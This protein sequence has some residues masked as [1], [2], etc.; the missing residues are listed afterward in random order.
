MNLERIEQLKRFLTETPE[1]PFLLYALAL[2]YL[3]EKPLE[4]K[5]YFETLLKEHPLY[6]G[7]YYHAAALYEALSEPAL[8]KQT[9]EK[10]IALAKKQLETKAL[11][12]LQNAYQNF[13]F[14]WE[15]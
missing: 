7:T 8:A 9:Y 11:Q 14:E 3:E 13:L 1:D 4:A 2:E 10:G 6:L 5:T 15:D 12:E